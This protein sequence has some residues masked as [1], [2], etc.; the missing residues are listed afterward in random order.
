MNVRHILF[1][2]VVITG[3][4][5]GCTHKEYRI[6]EF[7]PELSH[8][9]RNVQK[10]VVT[11]QTY[12]HDMQSIQIGTGFF[13]ASKGTL[14][15]NFHVI[16]NA[17]A[18]AVK[19]KAGEK[20][21]VDSV[22]AEDQAMDLVKLAVDIPEDKVHAIRIAVDVPQV[23]D[24][25]FVVGSPLGLEQ[26]VSEGIVSAIRRIP[27]LSPV[28]QISAPIS[29]GSS[30]SPVMNMNG[31]VIGVVSF[32]STAGQNINFAVSGKRI[33]ELTHMESALTIPEWSYGHTQEKP[34]LA[35]ELCKKGFNF[36]IRGEFKE[37][38]AFYQ[39]AT[40]QSPQS[41][42]AWYGLG[43]C[44]VG[45]DRPDD[46]IGA[47]RQAIESNPQDAFAHYNLGRYF[48][49][50]GRFE[51]AVETFQEAV[52]IDPENLPARFDL[53]VA[54]SQLGNLND[55]KLAYEAIIGM[56][57]DF[58][59]AH[60]HIGLTYI[61]LGRYEDAVLAEKKAVS[62]KPDF[63]PAY[64]AMGIAYGSLDNSIEEVSAYKEAI[65]IDPDYAPAHFNM[66]LVYLN[67][68]DKAS[69]LEEYQILKPLD[70]DLAQKLFNLIYK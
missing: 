34:K 35:Q 36:S 61:K 9:V 37:A 40:E 55:A 7:N 69:A 27:S 22:L 54:H 53:A 63:A 66:G 14:V 18:A 57:P 3:V 13:I 15:T 52:R 59:P 67:R 70:A 29:R 11:I 12:D 25:I 26:T 50:L 4:I 6:Q 60:H 31:K 24:R 10:A 48:T 68:R 46:A 64:F 47:Y 16:E 51:E 39:E 42:T 62:L 58:Y 41:T 65:R 45:L 44:Y 2:C 28:F 32:Q 33:E 1:L 8:L 20:F 23:A 43:A 38:L 21:W 30:G 56:R 5:I 17:Y 49:T 19:T